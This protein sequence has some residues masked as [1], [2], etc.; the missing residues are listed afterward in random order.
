MSVSLPSTKPDCGVFKA[1]GTQF[2]VNN[3]LKLTHDYWI[4]ENIQGS[5]IEFERLP[6]QEVVPMEYRH[7]R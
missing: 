4:I 2:C 6:V 3:W 5:C 1:G 7:S